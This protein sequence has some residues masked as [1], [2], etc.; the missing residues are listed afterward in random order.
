M[1]A[2]RLRFAP[3]AFWREIMESDGRVRYEHEPSG[4]SNLGA[5]RNRPVSYTHLTLPTKA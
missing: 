4:D 3:S 2:R 1:V 5:K